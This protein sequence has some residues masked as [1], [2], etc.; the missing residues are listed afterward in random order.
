MFFTVTASGMEF[1]GRLISAETKQ[2]QLEVK[3]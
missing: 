1:Q 3:M 2:H